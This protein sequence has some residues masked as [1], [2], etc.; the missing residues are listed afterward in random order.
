MRKAPL[1]DMSAK[2]QRVPP[3]SALT[4]HKVLPARIVG[5]DRIWVINLDR[6]RDRLERFMQAQPEM[7]GRINRMPAYDGNNLELTPELARLFAPNNFDWHKPTMGCAMSHLALWQKLADEPGDNPAW[8][9]LEDDARLES[10]WVAVV[11]KAFIHGQ[12]PAD[13]EV[14]FLGGILPKYR[15]FFDENV[16]QVTRAVARIKPDCV[17][18]SNPPGY[19][20]FCAYAYLLNKRGAKRLVDLVQSGDGIWMQ[21]DFFVSYTTPDLTP[22]RPVY[23]LNPLPAHSFQDFED[24]VARP[25]SE[26]AETEKVDSDIWKKDDRFS[27]EKVAGILDRGRKLDIHAALGLPAVKVAGPAVL[28]SSDASKKPRKKVGLV[29]VTRD[30]V[31]KLRV[32]LESIVRNTDSALYELH[33]FDNASSDATR[34][35]RSGS[36]PENIHFI[37]SEQNLG[38]VGAINHCLPILLEHEFVGFLND[39]IEVGPRWLEHLVGVL[40]RHAEVGAVGPLTSNDRDW[41]GYDRFNAG[42][43]KPNLPALADIDRNDVPAMAAAMSG[44][45]PGITLKD[46]HLAFFCVLFRSEVLRKVGH[47][48]MAFHELYLGDDDDYCKRIVASGYLLA[49]SFNA[50]VAH[51]SGSRSLLVD[52]HAGRYEAAQRIIAAKERSGAY[53]SSV[54][55]LDKNGDESRSRRSAPAERGHYTKKSALICVTRNNPGKLRTT[56]ES[57]L[58]HTNPEAYDLYIIDNASSKEH[59]DIYREV[60]AD[61]IKVIRS[62]RN[63]H[64]VGGINLGLETTKNYRYVGFL[65]DD[66]EVGPNWLQNLCDVL[67]RNE[68]VAAVGPMTS[69]ERDWQGYDRVRKF[70]PNWNVP[71]LENIDRNDVLAMSREIQKNDPLIRI[72]GMLA[73]FCVLMRRDVIDLVGLLDPDFAELYTCDDDDYCDRI[74]T[75]GYTLALSTKSYVA[76]YSG[77]SSSKVDAFSEKTKTANQLLARKKS[78]RQM[79]KERAAGAPGSPDSQRNQYPAASQP[80]TAG[81]PPGSVLPQNLGHMVLEGHLGGFFSEGD[82]GTYYPIMWSHL[83]RKHGIRSVLDVG[84]GRGYS[85]LYFKSLG[86]SIKGIDGSEEAR[87]T[88]LIGEDFVPADYAAAPSSVEGRFDL[89]WSC[90]FV[91]HVEEKFMANY[92]RDFRRGKYLAMTFA[93]PGQPGHHHVNCRPHEYWI[94]MLYSQG[95]DYLP[96]ETAELREFVRKDMEKSNSENGKGF[97]YHFIDRGLFFRRNEIFRNS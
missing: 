83:V 91:E 65:N 37:H 11:E 7:F 56:V 54:S 80:G 93:G 26:A 31:E 39:D 71:A 86:C 96:D 76:H 25:Y 78:E 22:P 27:E 8:L 66:I 3:A 73:F 2:V 15:E 88:N 40:E 14:L 68:D 49:L 34:Q 51:H 84:C 33:V 95:F 28:K 94:R 82:G 35:L 6:R 50:Y 61:Q 17:F 45:N 75:A 10:S 70:F 47:L 92:L 55:N 19:F 79:A 53:K 18:G 72:H 46:G 41:Q 89:V 24:G 1:S 42:P 23:F 4:V 64:W 20:H 67:D 30:S 90:E 58:R 74:Q 32:T 69:N 62:K 63:L 60:A 48:D 44:F 29:C 97:V 52:D 81:P 43:I 87:K 85:T 38:R 36:W 57:I 21:A 77:T 12:L 5:I 59:V 13:W 9:I 16:E